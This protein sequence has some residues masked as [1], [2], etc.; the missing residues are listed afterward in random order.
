MSGP[1]DWR[2]AVVHG[3]QVLVCPDCQTPGW[4]DGLDRCASCGSTALSKRLGVVVCRACGHEDAGAPTPAPAEPA[5]AAGGT[6]P[7]TGVAPDGPGRQGHLSEAGGSSAPGSGSR[8][9]TPA[10]PQRAAGGPDPDDPARAALAAEVAA[11]VDRVLGR[12]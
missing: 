1:S 2:R 3:A 8:R 11:A 4:T 12:G 9:S 5:P 6:G 10:G 7:E